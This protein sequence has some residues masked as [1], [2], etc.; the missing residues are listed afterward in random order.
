METFI[1]LLIRLFY[2]GFISFGSIYALHLHIQQKRDKKNYRK[3]ES[4]MKGLKEIFKRH[5]ERKNEVKLVPVV[6]TIP[7]AKIAL[8]LTKEPQLKQCIKQINDAIAR[9]NTM[10]YVGDKEKLHKETIEYITGL[11]Y[12]I[13]VLCYKERPD[14]IYRRRDE[15]FNEVF[16]NEGTTGKYTYNEQ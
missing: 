10:T 5:N 8:E 2:L 13:K 14:D 11:G 1:E 3:G 16:W 9:G 12:D 4:K 7:D 6:T 15:Y